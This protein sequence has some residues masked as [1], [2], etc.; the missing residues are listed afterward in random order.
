MSAENTKKPEWYGKHYAFFTNRACEYFPCHETA[1]EAAF[2]CLFCY[3]PLYMLGE[4]CGG[5]FKYLENG[6]KDCSRC[7][8][9]HRRE[10]YGHIIRKYREIAEAMRKTPEKP[11]E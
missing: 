5:N 8:L 6:S 9:P 4:K 10:G 1:D 11:E 3:C 7:L 2:N